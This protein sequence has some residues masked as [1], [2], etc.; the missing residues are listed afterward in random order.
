LRKSWQD[1]FLINFGLFFLFLERLNNF[2]S[3]I[4]FAIIKLSPINFLSKENEKGFFEE[5]KSWIFIEKAL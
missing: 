1:Y 2:I 4:H 3:F 5:K